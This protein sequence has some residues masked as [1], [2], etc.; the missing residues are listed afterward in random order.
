[1]IAVAPLLR[2]RHLSVSL[3]GVRAVQDFDIDIEPGDSVAMFGPNG[4]GKTTVFNA[5][6]RFVR[7][8]RDSSI[9]WRGQRVEKSK[10]FQLARS[11]LVRTFQNTAGVGDLN[12]VSNLLAAS[13]GRD[14]VV[15]EII[16]ILGLE[17]VQGVELATCSLATRK[18]VSIGMALV[19]SPEL[20]LLDEPLA[21]LDPQ[22]R[23]GVMSAL[24]RV[25]ASGV[26]IFLIEHDIGRAI[27][28]CS[29][30]VVLDNGKKVF[31]DVSDAARK[32]GVLW[33][34]QTRPN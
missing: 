13:R 20:L 5:I 17:S 12:V 26:A 22:D 1:V 24:Q 23:G 28:F 19:C 30:V 31:D 34:S 27:D 32:R 2:V 15:E 16:G 10:P 9:E 6:T 14:D 18:L 3:G 7:C 8:S 25:H 33:A 11:G 29:R 4:A 21:G